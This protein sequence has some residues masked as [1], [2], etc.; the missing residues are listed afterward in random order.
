[1]RGGWG[2]QSEE[3]E[4]R[5]ELGDDTGEEGRGEGGEVQG[6]EG[7]GGRVCNGV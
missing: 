3:R 1:M 6:E 5:L 2:A 4:G 7:R